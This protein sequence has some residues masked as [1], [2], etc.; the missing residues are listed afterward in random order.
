MIK[1]IALK[2]KG[3][4]S[5]FN[6]THVCDSVLA[7]WVRRCKAKILGCANNIK[8]TLLVQIAKTQGVHTWVRGWCL[9]KRNKRRA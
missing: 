3:Q 1:L 6:E 4:M 8:V 7:S 2:F 5:P 9:T